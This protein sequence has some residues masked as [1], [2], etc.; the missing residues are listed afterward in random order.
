MRGQRI[1]HLRKRTVVRFEFFLSSLTILVHSRPRVSVCVFGTIADG[2][3]LRVHV[4]LAT[5]DN[6]SCSLYN[7]LISC[8]MK[9]LRCAH[10]TCKAATSIHPVVPHS[11]CPL[12]RFAKYV[13]PVVPCLVF[14]PS[15]LYQ[16]TKGV[17]SLAGVN[18]AHPDLRAFKVRA[19]DQRVSLSATCRWL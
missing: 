14:C 1:I 2:Y 10:S 17:Q 16:E 3:G 13:H 6:D 4:H 12:R 18:R 7:R 9:P 5:Q 8:S 19:W 15:L 11:A